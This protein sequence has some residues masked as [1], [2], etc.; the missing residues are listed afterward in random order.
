MGLSAIISLIVFVI[1]VIGILSQKIDKTLISMLGAV[2]LLI[3][4]TFF[5]SDASY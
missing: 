2:F 4:G 3:I 1:V 5:S